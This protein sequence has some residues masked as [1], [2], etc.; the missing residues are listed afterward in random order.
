MRDRRMFSNSIIENDIFTELSFSTQCLYFHLILKA[1]DDGFVSSPKK[2]LRSIGATE[3]DLQKLI[4]IGYVDLF[5][6]GVMIINHWRIHNTIR[7]DRHKPTIF[8]KEFSQ[9]SLDESEKYIRKNN[10]TDW[11][12]NGCQLVTESE[13]NRLP[14]GC[15]LVA[16]SETNRLHNKVSNKVSNKLINKGVEEKNTFKKLTGEELKKL[17]GEFPNADIDKWNVH[18]ESYCKS[19]GK[20]YKKPYE[21]V[22]NWINQEPNK[23][24]KTQKDDYYEGLKKF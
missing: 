16:E 15:Q 22:R 2:I 14:N 9:L 7:N 6:S 4:E 8:Q 17:Q 23:F 20:T 1:D 3:D 11:L 21:T 24:L 19:R 18:Y 12:P 10:I 13:T 5:E